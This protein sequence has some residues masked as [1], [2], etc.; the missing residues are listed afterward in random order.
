MTSILIACTRVTPPGPRIIIAT[1]G[2]WLACA[3]AAYGWDDVNG[4]AVGD[5]ESIGRYAA[6]CM[7]GAARLPPDGTG[8]Q[9]VRLERNR[10]YGHPRLVRF[11]G[12]L[13]QQTDDVGLGLLPVGD[14]SQPRGGPMIEDHASHQVGLD[15]DIFFRLDLP[16]LPHEQREDLELP[17]LVDQ[18]RR[19]LDE[20]FG[21]A[22]FELLRLAASDPDVA[23]IFVS[24]FIKQAM[25]EQ[26]WQDRSFLRRLRPWF[27]HEDHMHVRLACPADSADCIEQAEPP[28]GDGCGAELATWFDRGPIPSRPPG[29]RRAP[30]LPMRCDVLR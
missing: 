15:V 4:P 11:V 13:A 19:E 7:I 22:Q 20:R 26:Q 3:A 25:C 23:R 1:I 14:M 30:E 24:P 28:A 8:Y 9:A 5:P 18:E 16:R 6:G 10:H 17:S 27:G 12:S 21:E 2:L 29:E